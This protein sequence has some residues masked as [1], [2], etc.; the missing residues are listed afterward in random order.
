MPSDVPCLAHSPRLFSPHPA[1]RP[2]RVLQRAVRAYVGRAD[3][4]GGMRL[5]SRPR[6]VIYIAI[7]IDSRI[8]NL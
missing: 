4:R 1:L 7:S 3:V 5:S 2:A 6:E 8:R